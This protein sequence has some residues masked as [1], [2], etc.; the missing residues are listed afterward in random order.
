MECCLQF[1]LLLYIILF[2]SNKEIYIY[3]YVQKPNYF[4]QLSPMLIQKF[5]GYGDSAL[6]QNL[7]QEMISEKKMNGLHCFLNGLI[8]GD[9]RKKYIVSCLYSQFLRRRRKHC[10]QTQILTSN[11]SSRCKICPLTIEGDRVRVFDEEIQLR[12]FSTCVTT[13]VVYLLRCSCPLFYV[14]LSDV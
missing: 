14:T 4:Y 8:H 2:F 5:L 6:K 12:T 3:I 1:L 11:R 10:I 7:H 13:G 9:S